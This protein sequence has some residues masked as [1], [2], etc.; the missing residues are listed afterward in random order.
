VFRS[1]TGTGC[2]HCDVRTEAE[3]T[4]EY[5]A[6]NTIQTGGNTPTDEIKVWVSVRVKKRELK[7]AVE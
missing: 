7:E 4:D 5:R 2:F 6:Y 3:E 1:I